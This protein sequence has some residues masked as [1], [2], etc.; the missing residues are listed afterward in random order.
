MVSKAAFTTHPRFQHTAARRRLAP[1]FPVTARPR[2]LFQHTAARRRLGV[3]R[4]KKPA[5]PLFQHTAA[6]R[7]LG[8]LKPYPYLYHGFN[9][10]PPEGGWQLPQPVRPPRAVSTHS[11]PK[12]AGA[13]PTKRQCRPYR[14]NTQPPE[15]GWEQYSRALAAMGLFILNFSLFR[16]FQHTA[17]RRRLGGSKRSAQR[18]MSVSTHSRPKAAGSIFHFQMMP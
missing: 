13:R 18:R 15:G 8:R 4:R 9:T 10:Q 11:R 6:R 5:K 2:T 12:A 14:F 1:V 3:P 7:R 17:A 16:L